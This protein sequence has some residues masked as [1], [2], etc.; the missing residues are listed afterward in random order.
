ML[1]MDWLSGLMSLS[2]ALSECTLW[3]EGRKVGREG[4][5][6][7]W[8]GGVICVHVLSAGDGQNISWA[9]FSRDS[10]FMDSCPHEILNPT[11]FF[12]L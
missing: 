5:E 2:L 9:T 8:E 12:C 7:G 10:I 1:C 4:R 6:G 3:E 11:K